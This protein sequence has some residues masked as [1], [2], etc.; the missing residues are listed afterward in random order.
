LVNDATKLSKKE[1]FTM[2][3]KYVPMKLETNAPGSA[4][5]SCRIVNPWRRPVL[6]L[7]CLAVC[8][9]WPLMAQATPAEQAFAQGQ[10][11]LAD[12]DLQGA[13]Q[14]LATAVKQDRENPEY[15]RQYTMLRRVVQLRQRLAAE[16][17]PRRWEYMARA[18]RAFYLDQGIY[19]EALE[20]DE[21]IHGK[22]QNAQSA[23]ML[24][25]TQLAMNHNAEAATMLG[26][27]APVEHT[28]TTRAL[29]VLALVREGKTD[30]ARG[31][32]EQVPLPEKAGPRTIY[33]VAWM[34]A[35]LG[36]ERE[37]M[38][39]LTRAMEELSPS[40]Q[41]GFVAHAEACPEFANLP[42]GAM[43]KVLQTKSKVPESKCSGG[44]SCAG[45]PMRGNCPKSQGQ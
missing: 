7:M 24:A 27:L 12:G 4:R 30:E 21:Q 3:R 11:L 40:Q 6:L 8:L 2:A 9:A 31:L 32:A 44:K 16:Q 45:C 33:T 26:R 23:S 13:L 37:A 17:D 14:A 15:V 39:L 35:A 20:L 42:K 10:Q 41:P 18:L 19:P 34:Q 36:N 1:M 28:P 38:A 5:S 43:A 22:L 25:E 29:R